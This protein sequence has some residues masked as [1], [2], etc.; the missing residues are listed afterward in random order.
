MT[1]DI[2]R[3]DEWVLTAEY[4][5]GLLSPSEAT[6]YEEVLA[7]DPELRSEY[8]FMAERI[9][10]LTDDVPAETPPR[11]MLARIER[12]LFDAPGTA[13][14]GGFLS[15]FGLLPAMVG[16]LAGAVAVLWLLD[17]LPMGGA[18]G[19]DGTGQPVL[20]A[21]I[22]ADGS[23]LVVQAAFDPQ[24]GVLRLQRTAGEPAPSGRAQELWLIAGDAAP[25]SLGLLGEGAESELA[26]S[27]D[28][29]D[30]LPGAL[31]AVSD[32]P[33][34]GSPTGSPTGDV[35]AAGELISL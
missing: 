16:G 25:V 5:L 12:T 10:R 1:D 15:R 27:P 17:V 11:D 2:D 9:A 29:R 24:T 18:P 4:I 35:L 26:I 34:G 31:L 22:A 20:Q 13:S 19:I 14:R 32:E 8:A 28:L 21:Q 3:K 23:A 33:E 7:V 30:A 6:A